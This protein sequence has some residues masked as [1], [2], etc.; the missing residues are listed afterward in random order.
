MWDAEVHGHGLAMPLGTLGTVL[1][2]AQKL[3]LYHMFCQLPSDEAAGVGAGGGEWGAVYK[4]RPEQ[5]RRYQCE[6]GKAGV[7][8]PTGTE[9][10]QA[11]SLC[12]AGPRSPWNISGGSW[13]SK[14]GMPK[15]L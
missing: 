3:P 7:A 10:S 1:S 5:E 13:G 6:K 9:T 15:W 14:G 4:S 2:L 8:A 12:K 11:T